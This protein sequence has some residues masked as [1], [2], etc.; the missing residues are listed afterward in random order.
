VFD[1][2]HKL[3][4][5]PFFEE[6]ASRE[7]GTRE[8]H[9]ATGGLVVLRLVDTWLESGLPAGAEDNWSIRSV[10]CS[11]DAMHDGAPIKTILGRVVD[12]LEEQKPDIHVVVTPLM[13]YAR[14]LEYDAK[15]FLAADVYHSV[16]A[17]LHPIEDG[18]ASAAAHM[19]LGY[20]YRSLHLVD[21]ATEAFTA[22][23]E[24]A[25][26]I[27][28]MV[29]V[30]LARVNEGHIAVLRGNL[31]RAEAI[32]DEA[33]ARATGPEYMDVRSRALH[34]RSGVAS[35]R[36]EYELAIQF[37]YSAFRHA[38][39]PIERDRILNDMAVAFSE[40]GVFSAARDAYLVLSATAQEQYM[41]WVATINLME[42]SSLTGGEM[43]F[44]LYRRQ[45][46]GVDLPP[47]LATGYQL[48]MGLGY[49]RF[50]DTKKAR[51]FLERAMA[52]AGEHGL[53]QYFFQAEEALLA[54]D[55]PPPHRVPADVSL[56]LEEVA[57]A[58]RELRESVGA[59]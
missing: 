38:Q 53:N 32:L 37:A 11:I 12:A 13:A 5:L 54:I 55:A 18:D 44:E 21:E 51:Q 19:R 16:L 29:S 48:Y 6:V 40:L 20:C 3:R 47:L 31:P 33:I 7:E 25:A 39:T 58:I 8:W 10:R 52:L 23:S 22:A 42:I 49:R 56:N 4:H 26:E 45:L 14:A 36:G 30:L 28:D 27:G 15:W 17:H 43:L 35:H 34:E 50:G 1:S 59:S 9:A 41:R 2:D 24:I 46:V 57:G